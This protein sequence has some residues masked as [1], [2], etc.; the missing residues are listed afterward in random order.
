MRDIPYFECNNETTVEYCRNK[1][2]IYI[3]LK[4]VDRERERRKKKKYVEI[5]LNMYLN[6]SHV[7][8]LN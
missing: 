8:M 4:R 1:K 2:K 5:K 6:M 7:K 3:H